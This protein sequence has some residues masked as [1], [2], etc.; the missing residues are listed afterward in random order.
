MPYHSIENV[1]M[2][3]SCTF[4]PLKN[5]LNIK[6]GFFMEKITNE[7]YMKK[8]FDL[9]LRGFGKTFP[10]PLVGAL[11]V[12]EDK[13]I[14]EGYHAGSGLPH[15]EMV[16]LDLAGEDSKGSDLYVNL[17][18]CC[19]YGKTPP[20]VDSII[21]SGIRRVFICNY[22]PN[23]KVNGQGVKKLRDSGIEVLTNI[24]ENEGLKLNEEFFKYITN[25]DP[26]C[27]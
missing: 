2:S 5:P 22:D 20:C 21:N 13:I 1:L 11:L 18:P 12:N 3:F 9:A 15:A 19:H 26:D 10:N 6:G 4:H 17:E 27:I 16:V 24:L 8:V 25:K 14:A 23:P 7:K